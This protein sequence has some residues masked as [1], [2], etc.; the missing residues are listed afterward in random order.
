MKS[1]TK[2]LIAA[3]ILPALAFIAFYFISKSFQCIPN[4]VDKHCGDSDGCSGKCKICPKGLTCDGSICQESFTPT[5]TLKSDTSPKGICYFDIDNTLTTA[6]GDRDEMMQHCL[7]NNFA[8]GIITASGRNIEDVCEGNNPKEHWMPRLLC[9]QF[10]R[11]GGKMFNSTRVV[12]GS[13]ILPSG[14]PSTGDQGHVKGFNM[15]HGKTVY[16]NVEDKCIVLFDDQQPVIDG[17]RRF[18]PALQTQC[19]H[20]SCGLGHVLDVETVKAKVAEMKSNGC[21]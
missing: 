13:T 9:E 16:P 10:N 17:V 21:Y 2:I 11:D 8:I 7:D 1:S 3:I 19:A 18:N 20:M 5:E 12:A 4:C 14:Y 6:K 15:I